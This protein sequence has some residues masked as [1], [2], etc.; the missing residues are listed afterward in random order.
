MAT[1]DSLSNFW[2]S[3]LNTPSPKTP[4]LVQVYGLYLLR[5]TSYSQFCDKIRD[6]SLP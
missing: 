2:L 3:P 5:K 6:F 4:Y 1:G